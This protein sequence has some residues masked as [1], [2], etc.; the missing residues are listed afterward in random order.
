MYIVNMMKIWSINWEKNNWTK[1]NG[2]TVDNLELV[3]KLYFYSQNSNIEFR[4]VRSH[5]KEPSKSDPSYK[6]WYGNDQADK[7]A[8]MAAESI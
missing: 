8:V 3:K 4:H 5:T 1:S 7:L 6:I 2:K